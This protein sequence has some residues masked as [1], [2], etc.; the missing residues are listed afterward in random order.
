MGGDGVGIVSSGFYCGW[1]WHAGAVEA[2]LSK[3]RQA[4]RSVVRS[5]SERGSVSTIRLRGGALAEIITA[6]SLLL[7]MCEFFV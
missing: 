3:E 4:A 5:A 7:V 1:A 6:F 2:A